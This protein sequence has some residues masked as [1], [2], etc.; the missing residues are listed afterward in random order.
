MEPERPGFLYFFATSVILW[1][2]AVYA[3]YYFF[4]KNP[5]INPPRKKRDEPQD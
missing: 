3:M 2:V 5:K 4:I 1:G